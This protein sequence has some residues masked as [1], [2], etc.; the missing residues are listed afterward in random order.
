MELIYQHAPATPVTRLGLILPKTGVCLDPP[1]K[2][3]LTR[4]TSQLMFRGAAGKSNEEINAQLERLGASMWG[5]LSNDV[6]NLRLV[7][8]T[9]NLDQAL[10]LFMESIHAPN[11]DEEEFS[12]LHAETLSGWISDREE[13]SQLRAQE[14]YLD[15]IFGNTALGYLPD[16]TLE[17]LKA[18]TLADVREHY[19]RFFQV[20]RRLLAVLSDLSQQEVAQQVTSR[21]TLPLA[22]GRQPEFPWDGF[23]PSRPKER[24]VWIVPDQEPNTNE[25]FA[26][27]FCARESSSDWHIHR[28]ISF[29]F[30]GDMNSRL[31]RILRGEH[32]FSYGA[33]CWFESSQ[34]RTPRN[35]LSPFSLYTFPA[36]EHTEQA[37]PMMLNLYEELVEKG[38]TDEEM[39]LARKA[40]TLSYPFHRD[41]PNKLLSI[42]VGEALYGIV[43]DDDETNRRKLA[44]VTPE[45]VLRVLR[46][47]HHPDQLGLVLMGDP[48]H[49]EP[50]ARKL[51]GVTHIEIRDG[52]STNQG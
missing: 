47:T 44:T 41:T 29:I 27:S 36:T 50:L 2:R 51:P 18:C 23:S 45:D 37:L 6:V 46:E 21:I 52:H 13:S 20:E 25:I 19:Q 8:L 32:G 1:D 34:G 9:E 30:G 31:F 7:S 5:S 10:T 38:V 15:L 39:E 12:R 16:G 22:T 3:G 43:T 17:G 24:R 40:L 49:L 4:L 33:S 11:F 35:Q 42:K 28:M 26:G 14:T 48:N